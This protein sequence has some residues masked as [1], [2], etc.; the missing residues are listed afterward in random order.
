MQEQKSQSKAVSGIETAYGHKF[1]MFNIDPESLDIRDIAHALSMNCRF[2]G[3]INKFYSVAEH[4]V[5]C[6]HLVPKHLA[7]EALMHDASE[8]YIADVASPIKKHL[9]NYK[10]LEDTIMLAIAKKFGFNYPL[11]KEVKEADLTMLSTEAHYLLPSHGTKDDVWFWAQRPA[12]SAGIPPYG[13]A[14]D[15]AKET[16]LARF[17]ELN[18]YDE[19]SGAEF[20]RPTALAGSAVENYDRD[21]SR[22]AR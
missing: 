10:E 4:S 3:H 12:I 16:F 20:V 19:T 21:Q 17:K 7:L 11:S 1:D 14:P 18:A 22:I 5:Y 13:Y 6:S 2:T 15:K 8:A 9:S